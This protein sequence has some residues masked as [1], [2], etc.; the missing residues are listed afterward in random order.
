[1]GDR[2]MLTEARIRE[3]VKPAGLDWIGALRGSAIRS[4]VESG[5]VQLSLFD[6]KD[7]IEVR[8]D[9]YPGERLMVCRN[10]L[11]AEERA[12]KRGE[13][14]VATEQLLAPIGEATRR[15]K[16]RLRGAERIGERVGH[17][18]GK[19]KV[20]KH[21]EWWIDAGG[22]LR[23][24][25]DAASIAAEAALDGLYVI[26][27]S[28]PDSEL[29][30]RATVSAYQRLSAVERA[31]RSLK[32]VDLRVRPVFH[33]TEGRVRAHVLLCMLAY[34]VEWH[35]RQR[36][37]PLLFD[38]GHPGG[39]G[40]ESVVASARPSA[41]AMD[42]AKRKRNADG[43]PVRSFRSLLAD[44]ATIARNTVVAGSSGAEP[45]EMLTRPT[46]LQRKAFELLGVRL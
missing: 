16:R 19:F 39:A 44:L 15:E 1:M 29:D 2:G 27:A 34:Y 30:A 14:L 25:R 24:R 10:P 26:R 35:M 31:F 33:R 36:L 41:S 20:A 40:R 8:S 22:A 12:R 5:A 11:L 17:H 23:Y 45:F 6:E 13:L 9:V 38:D 42:K 7:L 28:V 32:T 21:F 3:E 43:D 4:L 46:P 18:I 37:A